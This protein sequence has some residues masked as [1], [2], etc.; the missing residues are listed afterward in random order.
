VGS[1]SAHYHAADVFT[2]DRF[3]QWVQLA[4]VYDRAGRTVTH[5]LDGEAVSET[6]T[7]FDIPL[8]IGDAELGNW[9]VPV[10]RDNSHLR[11]LNGCMDEFML[12]ARALSREEIARLYEQ[13]RPPQ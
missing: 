3:G 11:Y 5:Y 10:R 2:P 4:V 12:F 1:P 9:N 6:P 7:K 8:R 13:G